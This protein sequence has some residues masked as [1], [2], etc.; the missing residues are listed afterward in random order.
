MSAKM[1][2]SLIGPALSLLFTVS[3][4]NAVHAQ[5]GGAPGSAMPGMQMPGMDSPKPTEAPGAESTQAGYAAIDTSQAVQ[6]RIGVKLGSVE[7]TALT[8]KTR[9]VGI[10]RPDE[11]KVAHIH[12]KTEGGSRSS[13]CPSRAKG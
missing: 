5:H 7:E 2:A 9:T 10:V 12:L 13:S 3:M 11:T 4:V 6:Q 1:Y 8:M